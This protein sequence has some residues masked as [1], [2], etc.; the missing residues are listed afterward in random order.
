MRWGYR[1]P[2]SARIDIATSTQLDGALRQPPRLVG[3]EQWPLDHCEE[4]SHDEVTHAKQ[5]QLPEGELVPG[6]VHRAPSAP[7]P[8]GALLSV[9]VPVRA[10]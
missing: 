6:R 7:S 2:T 3:E 4:Y 9:L 1:R 10:S 5:V 8:A